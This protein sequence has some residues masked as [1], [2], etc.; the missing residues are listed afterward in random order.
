VEQGPTGQVF[1][2]PAHPYTRAL[3]D[4]IP[5]RGWVPGSVAG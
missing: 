5:G 2:A 1:G 4:A 3:L